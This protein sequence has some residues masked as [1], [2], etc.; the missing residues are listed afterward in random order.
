MITIMLE[1][2]GNAHFLR[3]EKWID[4]AVR[5]SRRFMRGEMKTFPASCLQEA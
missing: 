2:H 5:L 4:W 3:C 1:S